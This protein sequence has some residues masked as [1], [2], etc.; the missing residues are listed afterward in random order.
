MS[1]IKHFLEVQGGKISEYIETFAGGELGGEINELGWWLAFLGDSYGA[2]HYQRLLIYHTEYLPKPLYK[3][4][5]TLFILD[6]LDQIEEFP[7]EKRAALL[8]LA[9]EEKD[10]IL[11]NMAFAL[12]EYSDIEHD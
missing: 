2:D 11:K 9:A 7:D 6:F 3:L 8:V 12:K 10:R 1:G 4:Y 5:V